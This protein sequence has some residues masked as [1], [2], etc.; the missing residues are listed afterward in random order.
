MGVIVGT[1]SY[2]A[3]EQASG[4]S[5]AIG[6]ATDVYALGA[7]LYECLTGKP[8][9]RGAS[10]LD[11]LL[12]VQMRSPIPP[13]Q[14]AADVPAELESICLKCLNKSPADR[15]GS[16]ADLADEL[17]RFLDGQSV[18]DGGMKTPEPAGDM[19]SRSTVT[20]VPTEGVAS[21]VPGK[22]IERRSRRWL[23]AAGVV[24]LLLVASVAWKLWPWGGKPA[25]L[26]GWIDMTVTEKGNP[27][28]QLL[29]LGDADA[30]P[31]KVGD[32]VRVEAKVNRLAWLYVL[33]IDTSG[34]VTPIYPWQD[35]KWDERPDNEEPVQRLS[36]PDESADVW[37]IL[38][39]PAGLEM[40]LLLAR[41]ER[42]PEDVD[43]A[44][45][46]ADL[47]PQKMEDKLDHA[48]FENGALVRDDELRA[49]SLKSRP[50]SNPMVRINGLLQKR[51]GGYFS[52]TRGVTFANRGGQKK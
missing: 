50:S 32:E 6:P 46:L 49:P 39:G 20:A 5:G 47:G 45:L 35:G 18:S 44:G 25:A 31:L 43:L 8:P 42:L 17:M 34:K 1:P 11:I 40:L 30:L 7:I 26:K 24:V 15:Y 9:F 27:A 37:E 19:F 12:Q 21:A 52:Y 23:I 41:E 48:W 28:R 36:L 13:R 38:P 14:V 3:P 16:A 22:R 10:H 4:D 51:L 2:M 33:W 29:R